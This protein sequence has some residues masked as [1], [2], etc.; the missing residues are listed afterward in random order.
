MSQMSICHAV[1]NQIAHEFNTNT[2][3]PTL[4]FVDFLSSRPRSK[5]SSNRAISIDFAVTDNYY[6]TSFDTIFVILG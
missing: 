6:V 2:G 5:L 3:T 1:G 4:F